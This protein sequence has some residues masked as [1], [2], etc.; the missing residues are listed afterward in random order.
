MVAVAGLSFY[1][2]VMT[3]PGLFTQRLNMLATQQLE[4][5]A[6]LGFEYRLEQSPNLRSWAPASSWTA[7]NGDYL[8]WG[9]GPLTNASLYWR[10]S[11]QAK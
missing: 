6:D 1:R 9:A 8:L 10:A 4:Y 7:G 11:R 3:N 5:Q 2:G